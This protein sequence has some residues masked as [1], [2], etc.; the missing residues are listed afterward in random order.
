M[1]VMIFRT[2][3]IFLTLLILMR[4]LGK[5]QMGELELS[6]LVVSF[7]VADVAAVPLQD[8]ELS[9]WYGLVPTL[10]IFL[11]ELLFSALTVKSITLRRW[12]CGKPCFLIVEG[13]IQQEYMRKSRFTVDE[14]SEELRSHDV[15]DPSQVQ[16][17]ILETDG[18]LNVILY[19]EFRPVSAGQMKLQSEDD[20]YAVVLIEDGKLLKQN[21][22]VMGKDEAWLKKELTKRGCASYR[23][24]YTMILYR[25]GKIYYAEKE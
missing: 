20:G 19:P 10:V 17:A 25:S 2:I 3:I 23:Q 1:L 15:N 16:Y 8:P 9:I 24:V 4:L 11:C 13:K 21:L 12:L 5:R 22:A 18:A 6:E 14:L 7:L